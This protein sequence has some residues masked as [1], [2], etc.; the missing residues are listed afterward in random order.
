MRQELRTVRQPQR[1]AVARPVPGA[2]IARRDLAD[3][4]ERAGVA[5]LDPFG[6]HLE[7]GPLAMRTGGA[8]EGGK[9]RRHCTGW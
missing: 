4:I 2:A 7:E 6:K 8:L 3:E 1:H 9:D 5:E